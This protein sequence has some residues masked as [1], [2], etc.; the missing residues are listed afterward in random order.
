MNRRCAIY[1]MARKLEDWRRSWHALHCSLSKSHSKLQTLCVDGS[2]VRR[3]KKAT[4]IY[5]YI[6][7]QSFIMVDDGAAI[8]DLFAFFEGRFGVAIAL[9]C[10]LARSPSAGSFNPN[11][12]ISPLSMPSLDVSESMNSRCL[13]YLRTRKLEDW[14]L[15][16]RAKRCSLS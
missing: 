8:H 12:F 3:K 5:T 4:K 6:F 14:M 1:F 9:L 11:D 15:S 16:R 13:S 10:V 2:W 7:T